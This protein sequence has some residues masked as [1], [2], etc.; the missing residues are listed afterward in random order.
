MNDNHRAIRKAQQIHEKS[1]DIVGETSDSAAD[2]ISQPEI[3]QNLS[4]DA[5]SSALP[6]NTQNHGGPPVESSDGA[7]EDVEEHMTE[8]RITNH[9]I[10]EMNLIASPMNRVKLY[11]LNESG[12]WDDMGTGHV[13]CEYVQSKGDLCLVMISEIT[14]EDPTQTKILESKVSRDDIYQLQGGVYQEV[15]KACN[16]FANDIL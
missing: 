13:C 9:Q 3:F 5:S 8:E 4:T 7:I 14:A 6:E 1:Q 16:S 11:H 12:L 15:K 2:N 10:E